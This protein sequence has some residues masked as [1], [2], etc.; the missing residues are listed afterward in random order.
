MTPH[1]R[2]RP[3]PTLGRPRNHHPRRNRP[4][5]RRHDPGP[6]EGE[7][8]DAYREITSLDWTWT[9]FGQDGEILGGGTSFAHARVAMR[10]A[11]AAK[12]TDR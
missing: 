3:R 11:D 5:G 10:A 8:V 2:P 1:L 7:V 6:R 12:E 4:A 9:H